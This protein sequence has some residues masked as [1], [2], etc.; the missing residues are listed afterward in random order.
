MPLLLSVGMV[1][2]SRLWVEWHWFEQFGWG[3]VLLRR[4]GLQLLLAMAGLTLALLLQRWLQRFWRAGHGRLAPRRFP[5]EP[6]PY[7][8]ALLLL[9][10]AQLLP[11]LLLLQLAQ[12]LLLR[13]FDPGRLHG[14]LPLHDGSL[15]GH[16]LLLSGL[17]SAV[18]VLCWRPQ[19]AG[20][21]LAGAA[22]M[23]AAIVIAR[24][25]GVWSLAVLIPAAGL[26]EHLLGADVTFAM[27][28]FPALALFLT[29]ALALLVQHLAAALWGQL[30][31]PPQF[32]DGRFAGFRPDQLLLLRLPLGLGALLVAASFWLGRHQLLLSTNGSVPGAGW[33]DVHVAL[34]LRSAAALVGLLSALLLWLPLARRGLRLP[35]LTLTASLLLLLP[36]LEALLA[37]LVQLLMVTPRELERERP[38]LQRSI[39]A[40]RAAFQLDRIRTRNVNPSPRITRADL[41]RSESTIRNIRLWDSQPLLATNRQLQ[42]LRVFYRFS[43]P[44]VDRYA[45]AAPGRPVQQQVIVTAR[46]IDSS[47]LQPSARTWLNRHLVFTHGQGFTVSPVNASGPDGLPEYFISDLGS[48]SRIS[49]SVELGISREQ[50]KA[51][52]P[53]GRP[54]LYYGTLH[55]PYALAPS[56]VREFNYPEG[57][58]NVYTHYS[59]TP[60]VPLAH[61]LA[62]LAASIYLGE[63]RLLVEGSLSPQTRLL[64]RREVRERLKRLV[65]F[66]S[67]EAEPYLVSV[68]LD[69]E[70]G[71]FRS[72]QHQY[73]IV[74]GFTSSRTYPY[75]EAIPNRPNLRY[76][77][78]SVKA[79]VDAYEGRVVLYVSE[80]KDPLISAWQRLFPELFSPFKTMPPAL[81]AH[82]RYP[83]PQFSLQ[84]AQLL[85]YHVTNP[86]VFYSGDDVWQIPKEIYGSEL[87]P[88]DP[89]HISAQ[90]SPDQPPE[91]LLLQPLTPLAR[92]NMVAWLAARSDAPNYGE[93][94]LLRFPSQTPILGPEQITALISQNPK[95]S[96]Q[97]GLWNR[98]GSEVI[99]GN[100]LV[101]PVGKALLYVEPVYLKAQK[102][103]LPTLIR[104]VV[105][106]GNRIAMEPTLAG[107]IEALLDPA[108]SQAAG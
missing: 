27:A 48:K 44:T 41:A 60:G 1:A 17:L 56:R 75:S 102:G 49:G 57:D 81:Q 20:R 97:F 46:E 105:S 33:V 70:S 54:S 92:P 88:L 10:A 62:R 66:V 39:H 6:L 94:E 32:S 100:L 86:S 3:S 23:A 43:E 83:L 68:R 40:T 35:A 82:I 80:P 89:Y 107:A 15:P 73:W 106:D 91:F 98:S 19:A 78:N 37:P 55:L 5:L 25:W 11:L 77:R 29:L 103:G 72:G 104:V 24:A 18:I 95:I 30:A 38:Y 34:P 13:P 101:V 59:G 7:V 2:A 71:P 52:I 76:L 14:L 42:Q 50:V 9:L 45:I 16:G 99:R 53:I 22:A 58:D 87:V 51:A 26:R 93:L 47:G 36:L 67:F 85:R 90:L 28:R 74:D 65:P 8:L 79:V 63:P 84:T 12:R 61:G 31:A 64:L 69:R 21:T 4:L 96:Q 108:R